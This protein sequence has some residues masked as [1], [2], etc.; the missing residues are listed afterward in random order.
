MRLPEYMVPA[1]VV[2][3]EALPLTSN[4][5][6]D[7]GA[8]AALRVVKPTPHGGLDSPRTLI[9]ERLAGIVCQLLKLEHVGLEDNFFLLGGH[10]LLG[11]Q[12]VARVNE[13]FGV[14]LPLR[15]LFDIPTVSGL[16]A[17]IERLVLAKLEAMTAEEVVSLQPR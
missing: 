17:E 10:S 9:E 7:R 6:V 11:A 13:G 3:L 12:L 5:K 1:G 15:T 2:R 16:S 14:A 8:L 4:G